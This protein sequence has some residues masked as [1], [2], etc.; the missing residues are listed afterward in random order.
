MNIFVSSNSVI[1][2][3][4][5]KNHDNELY[6]KIGLALVGALGVE[7]VLLEQA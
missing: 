2:N 3:F 6:L 1:R 4:F 5:Y 7:E